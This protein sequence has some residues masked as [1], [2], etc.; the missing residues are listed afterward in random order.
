MGK[1]QLLMNSRSGAH[2]CGSFNEFGASGFRYCMRTA[3]LVQTINA[4]ETGWF[5]KIAWVVVAFDLVFNLRHPNRCDRL[6]ASKGGVE[7]TIPSEHIQGGVEQV[8]TMAQTSNSLD[9][10]VAD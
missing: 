4:N 8:H 10:S 2:P 5:N 1:R 7:T 9:E 6:P 3:F